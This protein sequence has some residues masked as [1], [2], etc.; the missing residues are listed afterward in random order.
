MAARNITLK[1]G[2]ISISAKKETAI[3]KAEGY[4]NLCVGGQ[5]DGKGGLTPTHDGA[6]VT[7]PKTCDKCQV[8]I[9]DYS[10]LVKG[11]K[12]GAGY[13]VVAQEDIAEAKKD[14]ADQYKGLVD[15]IPHPAADFYAKTAPGESINYLTPADAANEDHYALLRKLITENPDV[16]FVSLHTPMSKTGLFV[17]NARDGVLVLEER[18]RTQSLKP[19]PSV[20][21]TVND[22]LYGMLLPMM[23]ATKTPYDP[24][25]YEDEYAKKIAELAANAV[26]VAGPAAADPTAPITPASDDDLMAQLAVLAS[27]AKNKAS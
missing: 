12:Q 13:A 18:A 3:E 25:K 2:L 1:F 19:A 21:G 26:I 17:V 5:P 7:M 27:A 8:T 20:G 22:A 23:E 14:T 9:G 24:D 6:P 10:A 4:K 16:A 15:L 11:I